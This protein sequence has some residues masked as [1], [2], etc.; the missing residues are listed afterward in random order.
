MR[1]RNGDLL[2]TGI[3]DEHRGGQFIHFLD[4]AEIFFEF[5]NLKV[6]L[7]DFFFGQTL[8]GAV[9]FHFAQLLQTTNPLTDG[10]KVGEH[11]AQPAGIYI[12]CAGALGFLTDGISGLLFGAYKK[13][14]TA[15]GG[16]LADIVISFFQ[17][18]YGLLQVDNVD[19]V[20]L[21]KDVL[22]HL[23][24]PAA[25]LVTEM[26]AGFQKLLHRYYCHVV[27]YLQ[28]FVFVTSAE[29]LFTRPPL[30]ALG[31]INRT[32]CVLPI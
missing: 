16:K 12:I 23:G 29:F 6:Q 4:A 30:R 28:K 9:R 26:H 3:D 18:F 17:L 11:T 31:Q 24:V 19:P 32:A 22:G 5:F 1:F 14:G 8:K 27:V 15:V 10:F 7:Y 21:G 13:N 25:G 2:L 20:T